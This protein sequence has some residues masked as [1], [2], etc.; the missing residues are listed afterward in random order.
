MERVFYILCAF[1]FINTQANWVAEYGPFKTLLYSD[2]ITCDHSR[3]L[4][5][6]VTAT[7]VYFYD[8]QNNFNYSYTIDSA[9]EAIQNAYNLDVKRRLILFVP[10][11]KSHIIRNAPEL[12]RVAFKNV[13][14]V[15]L[16]IIDHSIYTSA[17]GGKVKSYERS[18]NYAFD[19]GKAVGQL[20]TKFR[21]MGF[22]S[23][24]IHCIGHSLGSQILGYAGSTYIN[25]TSEKVWRITGIDPA[26]PCFSNSLIEDQLRSGC[27]EYVEVYH[28][29]AGGLGTT[30]VLADTD[31]FL[32]DGKTQPHCDASFLNSF[33]DSEARC[34]HKSC[35]K[36]WTETVGNPGWYLAWK[37]DSYKAF[38]KG[39]CAANEVTIAGYSNPGN[40][41][42]VFYASTGTYGVA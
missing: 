9:A 31:F 23:R 14:N 35:V 1:L 42:G 20:L 2:W 22:E 24:N 34:S 29:N 28:C 17:Q 11:Y 32:N 41:T 33:G 7:E 10:G 40:A 4:D 16:M 6:N 27:A 36:Y 18:V 26:G 13:P 21:L 25:M 12:I 3:D 8:F 15:Y 38:S 37:C 19:L 30:S 5:L 39:K